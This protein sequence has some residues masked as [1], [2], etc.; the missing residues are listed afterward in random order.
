M[1]FGVLTISLQVVSAPT[2]LGLVRSAPV[3]GVDSSFLRCRGRSP[4][5]PSVFSDLLLIFPPNSLQQGRAS[6]VRLFAGPL[7]FGVGYLRIQPLRIGV[8]LLLSGVALLRQLTP[9]IGAGLLE[10]GVVLLCR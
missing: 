4:V 10:F 9:W 6:P 3:R 2:L 5:G 1:Y 8:D 7:G